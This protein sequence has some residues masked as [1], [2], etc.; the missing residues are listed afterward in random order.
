MDLFFVCLSLVQTNNTI[1]QQINVKNVYPVSSA[2]IRTHN[3]LN[4]TT[5]PGQPPN[6]IFCIFPLFSSNYYTINI[7]D[8]RGTLTW[9]VSAESE[10]ADHLTATSD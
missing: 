8:F 3:L 4:I 10:H 5:R 6:G 9:I 1:L 2:G 7:V